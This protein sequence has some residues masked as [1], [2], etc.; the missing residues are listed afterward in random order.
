[1]HPKTKSD[2]AKKSVTTYYKDGLRGA[3]GWEGDGKHYHNGRAGKMGAA[4]GGDGHLDNP[5]P[6]PQSVYIWPPC[7]ASLAADAGLHWYPDF[8]HTAAD[9]LEVH[10]P[11]ICSNRGLFRIYS[12][13]FAREQEYKPVSLWATDLG[14]T[15][16]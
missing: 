4:W 6:P 8:S 9:R 11:F 2:K 16:P 1:M 12:T 13:I 7:C 3:R 15:T 10:L 14:W 5:P